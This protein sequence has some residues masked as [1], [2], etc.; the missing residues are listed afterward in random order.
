MLAEG[1][2]AE[3]I[4]VGVAHLA[5]EP[6][7]ASRRNQV[8]VRPLAHRNPLWIGTSAA[9]SGVVRKFNKLATL[10]NALTADDFAKVLDDYQP[11][12]VHS[13]S[14]VELT[15][16]MWKS[17]KDRGATIVHT[18]HDYDLM[19]IRAAL[20]KDEARCTKQHLACAAFSSVKRHYH[21][22]IDH[23]VGVSRSILQTHLDQGFFDGMPK[24]H[25]HVIW[26]PVRA[27]PAMPPSSAGQRTGPLTFG[28]LGRLVPEKGIMQLLDACRDMVGVD[29]WQLKIAGKAP[30]DDAF[31][32]ERIGSLPIELVGFVDPA[33]FFRDIDVLV[34]PSVWL[35]PFGL[36]IVEAYAS[37]VSV[38]GSDI[39]GVAEI[40]GSV[41]RAALFPADDVEA[42]ATKMKDVVRRG[43]D[44]IKPGDTSAVL[45][46]TKPEHVVRQYMQ[47]YRSA[48]DL[49]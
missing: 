33:A 27:A 18:L 9:H 13:H 38:I 43:R 31:L 32:R 49:M 17:A 44:G 11:D 48:L 34:V 40:V 14:M 16:R 19:C 39:A 42:M 47:V 5:P 36:T 15:P 10:F 26:N 45:E 6:A 8:D 23:V 1:C 28:F 2:A 29:G 30:K 41:D 20:Y 12:I 35:E 4:N 3:G 7:A 21:G 37:G 22:H 25:Q 46:R 24:S